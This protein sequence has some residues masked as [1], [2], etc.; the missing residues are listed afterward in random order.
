MDHQLGAAAVQTVDYGGQA[1][2]DLLEPVVELCFLENNIVTLLYYFS[3][4][5]FSLNI[6]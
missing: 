2:Y 3:T 1:L 4:F 5:F 6:D